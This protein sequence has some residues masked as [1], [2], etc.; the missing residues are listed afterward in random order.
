MQQITLTTDWTQITAIPA[1][2]QFF[3]SLEVLLSLG[4]A[5]DEI[6]FVCDNKQF[7]TN[8]SNMKIWAK[9]PFGKGR[10]VKYELV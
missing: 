7:Y 8:T 1:L 4:D 2:L 9:V 6:S 3:C 10:V 5:P